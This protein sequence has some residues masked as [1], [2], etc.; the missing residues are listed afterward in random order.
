MAAENQLTTQELWNDG[1]AMSVTLSQDPAD[2]TRLVINWTLPPTPHTTF[3][4]A[5]VL[6]SEEPFA[7]I[8]TPEDGKKYVASS[9]F[10]APADT[11]ADARVVW[12]GYKYFGDTIATSVT[13]TN[14]DPT[15][16]YYASI[17]A[18]SSILQYYPIGVKS[19]PLESSR[20]EKASDSYAGSI[21]RSS[22]PPSDPEDGEVYFD[23]FTSNVLIWTESL[24]AWSDTS[25]KTV[26]TGV[27]PAV[28]NTQL[29]FDLTTT[30]AKIFL[31]GMWFT[32]TPTN[33]RVKYGVS[34][35]PFN[36]FSVVGSLPEFANDGDIVYIRENAPYG[37]NLGSESI[38]VRT[39]GQWFSFSTDLIQIET[40]PSNWVN[41]KIGTELFGRQ[42]TPAAP[43]IGD[44]FYSTSVKELSVWSGTDWKKANGASEGSPSTDKVGIGTDGSYDERL[45]LIKILKGQMGWPAV[46]L[47]LNEEHFNIAIDNALQTFRQRADNA[48]AHRYVMF[49]L[50]PNQQIYYLNDPRTKSDKIVNILKIGRVNTLGSNQLNDPVFGQLLIPKFFN[51]G[52]NIDL[53]SI[54][55]MH[56][57][58][59]TFERI[60]AGNLIYT[61]DEAARQLM[62]HRHIPRSERVVLEVVMERSEQELMLDRWCQQWIQGWA[63]AELKEIL[64]LLRSK[65]SSI[66]G[67]NGGVTLNGDLLISEARLDFEDL[68]RQLNDY[69]VGNGGTNFGNTSFMI[70]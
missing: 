12:A 43:Q 52:G 16:V 40:A 57:L 22:V 59:E 33:L 7:G 60:F 67:P 14:T 62:I 2:T 58:S 27:F 29:F 42:G 8:H 51:N 41:P 20:F 63:M 39:M 30:S 5:I 35:I 17:H 4:G 25:D 65:Y 64:G 44:F 32:A 23:T 9:N 38:K 6:L 54:H 28:Q 31:A 18:A 50:N 55:L 26:S 10:A 69:E 48:Y 21:P 15:K 19:Y 3:N 49:T 53:V 68:Q 61:W 45:R 46:C 1:R 47:E 24:Q 56:Q 70:G 13:V 37:V 34:W 66:A 11:I 36:S